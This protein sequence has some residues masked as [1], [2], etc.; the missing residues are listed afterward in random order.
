MATTK[1]LKADDGYSAQMRSL[2]LRPWQ[3]PPCWIS[4]RELAWALAQPDDHRGV[5]RAAELRLRMRKC[6]VPKDHPDPVAACEAAEGARDRPA[7][8]KK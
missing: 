6:G 7:Q 4:D 3:F 8:R 2:N 1:K 5:R